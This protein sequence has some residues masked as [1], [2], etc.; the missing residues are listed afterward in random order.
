[1]DKQEDKQAGMHKRADAQTRKDKQTRIDKQE[2]KQARMDKRADGQIRTD[3]Q[4]AW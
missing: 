3:S 1:M 4:T 2:D